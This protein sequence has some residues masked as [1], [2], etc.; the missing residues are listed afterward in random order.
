MNRR[1]FLS[2]FGS[3]ALAGHAVAATP[4]PKPVCA[5]PKPV[6]KPPLRFN[7][8]PKYD[9]DHRCDNCGHESPQGRGTWVQSRDVGDRHEH[10]CPNCGNVWWHFDDGHVPSGEVKRYTLPQISGCESGN[11]PTQSRGFFRRR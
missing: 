3:L 7:S 1:V 6:A 10:T 4:N 8:G 11:C 2:I 9:P 5:D